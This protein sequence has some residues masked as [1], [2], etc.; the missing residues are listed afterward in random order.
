MQDLTVFIL[1]GV[2]NELAP[3]V[4]R[5]VTIL[6]KIMEGTLDGPERLV[7]RHRL[8]FHRCPTVLNPFQA[9]ATEDFFSVVD[10]IGNFVSEQ[11]KSKPSSGRQW[12]IK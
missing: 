6:W 3:K 8:K 4:A 5:D 1:Q 11:V 10:L 2:S 12:Q 9:Q 7:K